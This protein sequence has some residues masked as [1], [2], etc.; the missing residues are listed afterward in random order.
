MPMEGLWLL[1]F[2]AGS[3]IGSFLNV[4]VHRLPREESIVRPGSRCPSCKRP[5]AWR[6]NIPLISYLALRARCRHCRAP[7]S[8]RY[9]AVELS[10]GLATAAVL[11]R[12]G[13]G[14]VG[15]IYLVFVYGLIVSSFVDLEFRIIPDE[16]SLGGM[17]VG[18]LAS[19][20][21]PA[22]HGADSSWL[23]LGRSALGLGV[24]ASLLYLTG[25]LGDFLFKKESMGL[26]DVK[27]LGMAGSVLG[28]KFV[29]LTFF[30]SPM[31]A[32]IPG[33]FVLLSKKSHEIPYGPFL[34]LSMVA[35]LF[36]GEEL[37]RLSGMEDV[38]RIL[39]EYY[40]WPR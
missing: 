18:L 16:I 7:I 12:F 38:V 29:V 2:I 5:I 11:H 28:W 1:W 30:L 24:G 15:F 13:M 25:L 40:G 10:T 6:D 22:L 37:V 39:W 34:S 26:G 9:P 36:F 23:A 14:P 32:V 19:F 27:L 3:I 35:S 4:C 20:L 17:V 21:V 33:L 8:W 31:L